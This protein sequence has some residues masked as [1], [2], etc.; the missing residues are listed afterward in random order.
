[1]YCSKCGK[2]LNGNEKLCDVCGKRVRY[3]EN[4]AVANQQRK[5]N[6]SRRTLMKI[7]V[8]FL[9]AVFAAIFVILFTKF[10]INA[11][12]NTSTYPDESNSRPRVYCSECGGDGKVICPACRG[13][14]RIPLCQ[15]CRG[16]RKIR[17]VSC[18][19]KGMY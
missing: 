12:L 13:E 17:C 11:V 6:Q 19:G 14:T 1:M 10:T 8:I 9:V 18:G 2:E 5:I 15:Y 16:E 7:T 4:K 3:N